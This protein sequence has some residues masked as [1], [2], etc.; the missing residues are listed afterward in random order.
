MKFNNSY[1]FPFLF[2]GCRHKRG[3]D[4]KYPHQ[5]VLRVSNDMNEK[6]NVQFIIFFRLKVFASVP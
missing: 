4:K 3:A 1:L 2:I 5:H 6:L